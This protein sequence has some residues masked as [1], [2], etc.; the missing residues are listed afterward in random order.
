MCVCSLMTTYVLRTMAVVRHSGECRTR[1]WPA[2]Q[3][4]WSRLLRTCGPQW[5]LIMSL[6]RATLRQ[7]MAKSDI[8]VMVRCMACPLFIGT[9]RCLGVRWCPIIL[10]ELKMSIVGSCCKS[11][12]VCESLNLPGRLTT[13]L[14]CQGENFLA[15]RPDIGDPEVKATSML[16]SSHSSWLWAMLLCLRRLRAGRFIDAP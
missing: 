6:S 16:P 14:W 3:S 9:S 10:I 15:D 7:T 5:V 11:A 12:A 1:S 13:L 2:L 8:S 4:K